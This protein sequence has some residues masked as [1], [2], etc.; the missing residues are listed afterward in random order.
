MFGLFAIVCGVHVCKCT[1]KWSSCA[2]WKFDFF[3]HLFLDLSFLRRRMC[4]TVITSTCVC[5]CHGW[6]AWNQYCCIPA[7][8][9]QI[10]S[11]D[12]VDDDAGELAMSLGYSVFNRCHFVVPRCCLLKLMYA[13]LYIQRDLPQFVG[14]CNFIPYTAAQPKWIFE[15][16]LQVFINPCVCS[17]SI[18]YLDTRQDL[19]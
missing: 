17:Y 5:V 16:S 9:L 8:Q 10:S 14:N 4:H 19:S 15:A 2:L 18:C 7:E 1:A 3:S 6:W 11:I 12:R 13:V